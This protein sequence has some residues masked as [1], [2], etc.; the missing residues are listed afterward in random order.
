MTSPQESGFGDLLRQLRH[1]AGM[2]QTD[3]AAAAG[4]S[5]SFISSLEKGDRV[6]DVTV[7]AER[8]VSAL[9]LQDD[10]ALAA[11]LV[12]AALMAR[13]QTQPV[14]VSVT[15]H[16]T[17]AVEEVD[18][19]ETAWLPA[20]PTP[21]VGRGRDLDLICRRLAGHQGRLLTFTGAPGVGKTRLA[22]EVAQRMAPVYADGACFADFTAI[23]DAA[24]APAAL[25][26]ALNLELGRSEAATQV[27]A[28]LRRRELLLVLDNMEQILD[29][30]AFVREVLAACPGVRIIATSR[31]R[32]HLR[33]EQRFRVAPLDLSAAVELFAARAAAND[34]HFTV[35][36]ANRRTVEQICRELDCLPLAIELCAAHVAV[37]TPD[38]L[39]ARLRDH[40]LD[41]LRDGPSDLPVR[42][43][44]LANAIH[45][46]YLLLTPRQQKLL[47]WLAPFVGGFDLAAITFLGYT[48]DDLKALVDKSLVHVAV[49]QTDGAHYALFATI[50][51]YAHDRVVAAEEDRAA[52]RTH[53]A[54]FLALAEEM[55]TQP[56]APP[57]SARLDTLSH[58]LDNLRAALRYW[59]AARAHE[60]VRLAAALREFWYG[61]GHLA[62]GRAWLA[63]ALA[64]DEIA[65]A[66]RGYALLSA[67]QLAH[68]QG[69]HADARAALDAALEVFTDLGDGRGRAAVLNELAWLHFD[70]HAPTAAVNCFEESIA[71]VRPLA[72][73]AWLAV[74]LSST[75]MVLGY[76]DRHDPRVRAYF[77]EAIDLHRT[78]NDPNGRAHALL[79]LSVVDGLEGCYAE[80][81]QRAEEA[82]DVLLALDR[83]RDLAWAYEVTGESRWF[84]GDLDGA[85][86][87]FRQARAI[88][89]ELG[90]A[91][92]IMLT[93]HHFGQIARRRGQF[94]A[95]Q[96]HYRTSIRLALQQEDARMVGRCLAGLA[97]LAFAAGDTARAAL[98]LAAAW[99]RFDSVPPFLAPC[100]EDDYQEVRREVGAALHP[101][102]LAEAWALGQSLAPESLLPVA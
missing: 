7:V 63:Q 31:E 27:I 58:N 67:G 17:V 13:G 91:E 36:T 6:P 46:S 98:L 94:A 41:M 69:D 57:A 48:T 99:Q 71:L 80:A 49:G 33:G 43:H 4:Y 52:Q 29:A 79:Q 82:L 20:P 30:A 44:T 38:A 45:R 47:R 37:Y 11:R 66:A 8:F 28:H 39:L 68:N 96:E 101:T 16:V 42:H 54:C 1:R 62:E 81:R 65:N 15:R 23:E 21:L 10:M 5:V 35:T 86:D 9:A 75:A 56:G 12:E 51:D 70:A 90:V 78:A 74:L 18:L 55:A 87:A 40:R 89:E 73:P 32:L 93:E 59:I 85:D 26:L 61:R 83:P 22:L 2:T 50:R 25:A 34:P 88:F 102:A 97:A 76:Q 92:G 77:A 19:P 84:C 100:D 95:A 3:L 14:S 53:A 24:S 72:D 60:A 64:V